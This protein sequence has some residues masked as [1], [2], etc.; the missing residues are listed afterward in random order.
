MNWRSRLIEGLVI[1]LIVAAVTRLA[2]GL[3]MPIVPYL[4]VLLALF[5]LLRWIFQGR[6]S[7]W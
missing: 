4:L 7:R 3:I 2:F 6:G 5:T 1:V